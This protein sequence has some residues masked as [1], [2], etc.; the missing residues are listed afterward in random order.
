MLDQGVGPATE[1]GGGGGGEKR[2]A[3][4]L[5]LKIRGIE[6]SDKLWKN[7]TGVFVEFIT[8]DAEPYKKH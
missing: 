6:R 5:E 7:I 2:G 4:L 1:R 3:L 8:Y